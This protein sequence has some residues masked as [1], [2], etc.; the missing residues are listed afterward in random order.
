MAIT[1]RG[2]HHQKA[3]R[4][5]IGKGV[6]VK[7][8]GSDGDMQLRSTNS[9]LML[10]VKYGGQ[11]Y[12]MGEGASRISGEDGGNP[13]ATTQYGGNTFIDKTK[14]HLYI[15]GNIVLG[16]KRHL[17]T[18][19]GQSKSYALDPDSSPKTNI[20]LTSRLLNYT[21]GNN[22]G[23]TA[24]S[25]DAPYVKGISM[26]LEQTHGIIF[27]GDANSH[28]YIKETADDVLDMYVGGDKIFEA[29]EAG[30]GNNFDFWDNV[31]VRL[32]ATTNSATAASTLQFD[33]Q[34]GTSA[35]TCYGQDGDLIG[36]IVFQGRN[37]GASNIIDGSPVAQPI[38]FGKIES[39][40]ADASDG[41][42]TGLLEIDSSG[43]IFLDAGGDITLDAAGSDINFNVAGTGPRLNWNSGQGLRIYSPNDLNDMF[44]ILVGI[45][46]GATT[47][48]TNDAS[49][50]QG[51]LSIAPDGD[52]E[53]NPATGV[54]IAKNN[55]TEFSAANSS[56]AGM[57]L[58][59]T[60]ITYTTGAYQATTTSHANIMKNFD[61]ADHY[62]KVSFVVPPSNRVKIKVFLPY[63]V[64][65]DG[66]LELGLATDTS[67][68]ALDTKY[69]NFVWDV[70]ESDGVM[71]NQEWNINGADHSWSAGQSKTLYCTIKEGTAGGRIFFGKGVSTTY[72]G[73][74]IMEAIALPATIADGT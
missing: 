5:I 46:H 71:V 9:G 24:L 64:S 56:Y 37:D 3:F 13:I 63:C 16:G 44:N 21:G 8:E 53:F 1:P 68:T 47:I 10:Y 17:P 23:L 43:D 2:L 61:S 4:I 45:D 40:I 54:Y 57:I 7:G 66:L 25:S 39:T 26:L 30:L 59:A 12:Q 74:W 33:T 20:G 60:E 58:G 22:K 72:Y 42:D 65:C 51:Y 32:K 6:P 18:I 67:A 19:D 62:L 52:L 73:S 28:T 27:D 41:T 15:G 34:R 48:S 29:S 35:T 55:G 38:I 31:D 69:N 49:G 36:K 11:W 50:S 70:D 14:G